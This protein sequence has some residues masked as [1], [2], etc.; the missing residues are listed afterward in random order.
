MHDR[1]FSVLHFVFE[2]LRFLPDLIILRADR[3]QIAVNPRGRVDLSLVGNVEQLR[4]L[5]IPEFLQISFGLE[6]FLQ[7][8]IFDCLLLNIDFHFSEF[9]QFLLEL[10]SKGVLFGVLRLELSQSL[11]RFFEG[12]G[13]ISIL[14]LTHANGLILLG[15]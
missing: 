2:C 9:A 14:L 7:I 10:L 8:T 11:V 15:Q 12:F 4:L 13:N 1:R 5:F 3:F 6:H